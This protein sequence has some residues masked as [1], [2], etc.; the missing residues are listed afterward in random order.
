MHV[1]KELHELP[2]LPMTYFGN[3]L[4]LIKRQVSRL[5]MLEYL[6]GLNTLLSNNRGSYVCPYNQIA[7]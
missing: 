4:K 3:I 2:K 6:G 7:T 5:A 1:R